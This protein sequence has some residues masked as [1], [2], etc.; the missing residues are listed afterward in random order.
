MGSFFFAPCRFHHENWNVF[1]FTTRF[2]SC[3]FQWSDF[4]HHSKLP[5]HHFAVKKKIF[6][7]FF[8]FEPLFFFQLCVN[9]WLFLLLSS[10][11]SPFDQLTAYIFH[12]IPI[13]TFVGV[14]FIHILHH[15]S[16]T[17]RL[18]EKHT[19]NFHL[20][21]SS[22]L[23]LK[24]YRNTY[25]FTTIF[26]SRLTNIFNYH[27]SS[28]NWIEINKIQFFLV[29]FFSPLQLNSSLYLPTIDPWS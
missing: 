19:H 5:V 23:S 3:I 11:F 26:S 29:I 24:I 16:N 10:D 2:R 9:K 27:Y 25:D 14:F 20:H 7:L 13:F 18:S 17:T 4:N 28:C 1:Y 15:F 21:S 22:D 6:L 12:D 8:L